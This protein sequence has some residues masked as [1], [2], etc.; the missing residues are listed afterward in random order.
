MH[1]VLQLSQYNAVQSRTLSL[2]HDL[3]RSHSILIA[4]IEM[5]RIHLQ[6]EYIVSFYN[7]FRVWWVGSE[8]NY[9]V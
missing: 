7:D 4:L 9:L 5:Y 1:E 8:I 3:A 2:L 6:S